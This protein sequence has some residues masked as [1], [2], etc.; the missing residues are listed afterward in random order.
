MTSQTV[1]ASCYCLL[2]QSKKASAVQSH[3]LESSQSDLVYVHLRRSPAGEK[4]LI[5]ARKSLLKSLSTHVQ[6]HYPNASYGVYPIENDSK[7]AIVMVAN[8]YSPNNFW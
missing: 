7:I 5:I 4:Y 6:E 1:K 2:T 8:K 3:V